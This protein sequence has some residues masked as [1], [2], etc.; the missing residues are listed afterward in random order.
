[1]PSSRPAHYYLRYLDSC[2]FMDFN[3]YG[4]E[5]IQLVRISFDGYGC[6]NV[7]NAI[8][9]NLVDAQAFK[10]MMNTGMLDQALLLNIV[11]RTI[12]DNSAQLWEEALVKYGLL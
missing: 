11:K 3:R 8:P 2:V 5:Q 10:G 1:M 9:M 6:C 12:A 4:T 7:P